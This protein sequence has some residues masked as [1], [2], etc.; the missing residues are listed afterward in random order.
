MGY[1]FSFPLKYFSLWF[2]IC[3]LCLGVVDSGLI[4]SIPINLV[5]FRKLLSYNNLFY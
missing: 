5:F 4:N 3:L 2:V 1:Y